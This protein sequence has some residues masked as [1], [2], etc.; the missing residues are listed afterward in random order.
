MDF[1][2]VTAE[3]LD[4]MVGDGHVV[5]KKI[6]TDQWV[7]MFG[8]EQIGTVL[9]DNFKDEQTVSIGERVVSRWTNR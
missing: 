1:S 9:T 7:L 5:L 6:M 3:E 8:E 2:Q 4:R